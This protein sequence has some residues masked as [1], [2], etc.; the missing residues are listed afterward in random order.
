MPLKIYPEINK[1]YIFQ[2]LKYNHMTD[3]T[4]LEKLA[5]FQ[6]SIN[7]FPDLKAIIIK[8]NSLQKTVLSL[9]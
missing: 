7:Q 2:T 1:K 4:K 8:I 5:E 3:A 6:E 9:N